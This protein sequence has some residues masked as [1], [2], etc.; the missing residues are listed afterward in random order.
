MDV[1][2]SENLSLSAQDSGQVESVSYAPI[3]VF[4]KI[5]WVIAAVSMR[6]GGVSQIPYRSLNLAYHVGDMDALVTEN[7]RR[8]YG[9]LGI[10]ASSI[11]LAQQAHGNE[12]AIVGKSQA[13][14]GAYSHETAIPETD[15]MIT[16]SR[17]V[18]LA[19]LTADCVPALIVDPVR[20]VVGV[21]HAGWRGTLLM[22]VSRTILK[23]RDAFGTKPADCLAALGPSIGPC[24][25]TVGEDVRSQ[26]LRAFGS[27]CVV[28]DRLDLQQA[29]KTQLVNIGVSEINISSLGGCTAC[30]LNRFY[31]YRGEGGRTGRIM[32]VIGI[33]DS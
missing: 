13:G 12:V 29:V 15:S 27:E 17:S 14:C 7:R 22:I 18:A 19:V 28:E 8:F 10:D 5:P 23:M 30:N 6:L 1:K 26:F 24:C 32:S 21:A 20:E 33:F 16:A 2:H 11:V 4:Q 25:Y 9:G 31:S 3:P